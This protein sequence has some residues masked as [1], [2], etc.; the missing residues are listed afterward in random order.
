MSLAKIPQRRPSL[1]RKEAVPK[2]QSW[3]EEPQGP[4]RTAALI[5]SKTWDESGPNWL[6]AEIWPLVKHQRE[7]WVAGGAEGAAVASVQSRL[8]RQ[9]HPEGNLAGS[10]ICFLLRMEVP[11]LG[12]PLPDHATVGGEAPAVW[13]HFAEK[14]PLW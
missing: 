14:T 5:P 3:A 13:P 7:A 10:P 4:R 2:A 9:T 8:P 1:E 12:W 6:Q 11:H